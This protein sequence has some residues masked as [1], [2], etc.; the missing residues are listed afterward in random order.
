[1]E[2]TSAK[3]SEKTIESECPDEELKTTNEPIK[4]KNKQSLHLKTPHSR[5]E[6]VVVSWLTATFYPGRL[7]QSL[8]K[9]SDSRGSEYRR[10][11]HYFTTIEPLGA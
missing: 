2:F 3:E 7:Q 11:L 10:T 5:A 6:E 9:A 8:N 4:N 1:M